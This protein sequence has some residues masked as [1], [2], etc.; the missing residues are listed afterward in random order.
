MQQ[1]VVF[2]YGTLKRGECNHSVMLRAG[3]EFVREDRAPGKVY[4]PFPFARQREKGDTSSWIH[5]EVY[6][7]SDKALARLDAFEG[8]P[9]AY[10]RTLVRL[11]SGEHAGIYYYIRDLS[12]FSRPIPSGVWSSGK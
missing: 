3:A 2:V 4:G 9:H 11:E 12:A 1:N 6:L 8:H 10:C 7:V 5:G